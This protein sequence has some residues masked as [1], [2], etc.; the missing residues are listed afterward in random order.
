ML[1]QHISFNFLKSKVSD[2][3]TTDD[4][5]LSLMGKKQKKIANFIELLYMVLFPLII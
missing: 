5:N 1:E 2:L 3:A 4:A